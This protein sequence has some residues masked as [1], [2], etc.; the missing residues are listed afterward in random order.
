MMSNLIDAIGA[1]GN[2]ILVLVILGIAAV[3]DG[4]RLTAR[5]LRP[6]RQTGVAPT[7]GETR[8]SGVYCG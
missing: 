4:V 1:F 6:T 3:V 8:S 7:P 5:E 2:P